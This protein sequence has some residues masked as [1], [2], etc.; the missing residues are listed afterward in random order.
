MPYRRGLAVGNPEGDNTMKTIIKN[1]DGDVVTCINVMHLFTYDVEQIVS[2]LLEDNRSSDGDIEITLDD[3]MERVK[4]LSDN[5]FD[6]NS[7]QLIFQDQD[8]T[9]L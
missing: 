7:G 1:D 8:G 6:A 2:D 4:I 5:D 9:D 3:V